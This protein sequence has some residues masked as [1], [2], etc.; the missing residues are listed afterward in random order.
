LST[1]VQN[2][3]AKRSACYTSQPFWRVCGWVGS[4]G[5]R[6]GNVSPESGAFDERCAEKNNSATS[7]CSS[8]W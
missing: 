4:S 7:G 1:I 5:F 3:E 6:P 2:I 8:A